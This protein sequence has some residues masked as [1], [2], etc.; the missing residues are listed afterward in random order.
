[1]SRLF[2][3][4]LVDSVYFLCPSIVCLNP[5]YSKNVST[6]VGQSFLKIIDEEFPADHPLHKIFNRNTVKISYSC[7][8]NIESRESISLFAC[9]RSLQ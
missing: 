6:N 7:M 4:E 9:R 2:V 1:M 8:P 5:P 3:V